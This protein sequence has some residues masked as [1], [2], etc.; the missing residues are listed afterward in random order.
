MPALLDRDA[1]RR[2]VEGFL[3]RELA[4]GSIRAP[5]CGRGPRPRAA[6][7]ARRAGPGAPTEE[8]LEESENGSSLPKISCIS[9]SLIVRT[10]ASAT[11]VDGQALPP[12]ER[13]GAPATAR[14]PAALLLGL[15]V[16]PPVGPESSYLRRFS[17]R[18]APR[19]LR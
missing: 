7:F 6:P 4:L 14:P 19:M 8:R 9:S 17:D 11:H 13:T 15:L 12:A 18:R 16:H 1:A 2:T 5:F 3:Q 10:A